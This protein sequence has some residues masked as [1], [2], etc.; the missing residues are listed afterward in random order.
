MSK[1]TWLHFSD[2]HF[3]S[4][5]TFAMAHAR[6]SLYSF[7]K[8]NKISCDYLFITGDIADKGDYSE[9]LA[10]A[11]NLINSITFNTSCENIFWSVGNHD[12]ERGITLKNKVIKKIRENTNPREIYQKYICDDN[13]I[14]K[15]I[16]CKN[17]MAKYHSN[18]K[19]ITGFDFPND[20]V[21]EHRFVHSI[22]DFNL[23]ILNTCITSCDENDTGKLLITDPKLLDLFDGLDKT[24]PTI[25]L[26]HHGKDFFNPNEYDDLGILF[27]DRV[28][29]Y[30]CGH[31]H[32]LG[33]SRFD[34]ARNDIH[35]LTCGGG[36]ID[37]YSKLVFMYGEY[38][39]GT[40]KIT[41]YSFAETGTR[42][43][44]VDYK[45]HRR[46]DENQL[47]KIN[48]LTE[49]KVKIANDRF[50]M[51][52]WFDDKNNAQNNQDSFDE[53]LE[54]LEKRDCFYLK[55]IKEVEDYINKKLMN[56]FE[57]RKSEISKKVKEGIKLSDEEK[58]MLISRHESFK[59]NVHT[60]SYGR[61][62][63]MHVFKNGA[64]IYMQKDISDQEHLLY[65]AHELGH[66]L[67]HFGFFG[68][69]EIDE[70]QATKFAHLI[71]D[72]RNKKNKI[73]KKY[74]FESD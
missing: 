71:L 30:L 44:G 22:K 36:K 66:L 32:L 46:L 42:E 8:N 23:I 15:E 26:G 28:D 27:D 41:P 25:V 19:L 5:D 50:S 7:L 58:E 69:N 62:A 24:K 4:G 16:L 74:F 20:V 60:L 13:S 67:Q 43:W 10:S 38:E 64:V 59:I 68:K 18:Y 55:L 51:Y 52:K 21:N 57:L 39:E 11:K 17:G 53:F 6:K 33:Y 2:L 14:E 3:N 48:R 9:S 34:N 49:P 45:L 72:I 70:P 61:R 37:G 12:I 31:S 1:F 29:L 35:Q 63:T 56:V 47:L 40:I 73:D 65:L 54:S